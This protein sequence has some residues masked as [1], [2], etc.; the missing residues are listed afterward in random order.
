MGMSIRCK[1]CGDVIASKHVHDFVRCKC[2]SI[3]IY[4]GDDDTRIL[5]DSWKIAERHGEIY[6]V[7]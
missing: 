3:A 1:E 4:G 6:D 5:G 2:G 7:Q